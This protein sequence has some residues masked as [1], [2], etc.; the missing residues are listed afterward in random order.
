MNCVDRIA[1]IV[2]AAVG[3]G[4]FRALRK[5]NEKRAVLAAF[6]GNTVFGSYIRPVKDQVNAQILGNRDTAVI[7]FKVIDAVAF[8][9]IRAVLRFDY[10]RALIGGTDNNEDIKEITKMYIY[11]NGN[12]LEV[13]LAKNSSVDALV[14]LLK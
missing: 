3:N 7:S 8:N 9:L 10:R 13:T 2:R 14:E 12:K 6:N 4:I 11:I 1:R 5:G